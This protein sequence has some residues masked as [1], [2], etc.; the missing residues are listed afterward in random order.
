MHNKN[1]LQFFFLFM[2]NQ[3]KS[4]ERFLYIWVVSLTFFSELELF[5]IILWF[6]D[7][8]AARETRVWQSRAKWSFGPF[9]TAPPVYEK[10][11]TAGSRVDYEQKSKFSGHIRASFCALSQ[12]Y[13]RARVDTHVLKMAAGYSVAVYHSAWIRCQVDSEKSSSAVS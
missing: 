10:D 2:I 3:W 12:L 13:R 8:A 1:A 6:S 9:P 5:L 4:A 11:K 7:Q